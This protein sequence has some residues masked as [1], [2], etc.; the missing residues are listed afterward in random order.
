MKV[1]LLRD[2]AR[3]G[4][5]Y[6]IKEVPD[7]HALNFLIPQKLALTATSEHKKRVEALRAHQNESL[8]ADLERFNDASKAL[9]KKGLTIA[10]EAN[11]QGHLFKGIK[12]EDIVKAASEV[13]V[14]IAKEHLDLAHPLKSVGEHQITLRSGSESSIFTLSLIKK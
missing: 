11:E 9:A 3:I 4:R 7:G 8:A 12:S 6:E 1:I 13:G 2:V 10:A 5:R 14:V